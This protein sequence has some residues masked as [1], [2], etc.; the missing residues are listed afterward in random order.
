V[1]HDI[2]LS[3]RVRASREQIWRACSEPQGLA[4]WQADEVRGNCNPGGTIQLE[5]GALGVSLALR[6]TEWEAGSRIGF[7]QPD[8][9]VRLEISDETV[10]LTQEGISPGA[11]LQGLTSSWR[12]ALAQLAH[13]LERH[14]GRARRVH[15]TTEIVPA[16]AELVH[17]AMTELELARGWLSPDGAIPA[18]GFAY[19]FHLHDGS[20]LSGRVLANSHGRDIALTCTEAGEASLAFRT[21]PTGVANQR[22]VA[23]VWSEWGAPTEAGRQR[24]AALSS[25]LEEL[26]RMLGRRGIA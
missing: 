7:E 6:V 22:L 21:F 26:R 18:R 14:P 9:L 10:H 5:W 11:D 2:R 25:A 17:M 16:P 13:S 20:W 19:G 12:V 8:G 3:Q 23:L 4:N 15:W 1:T 24:R